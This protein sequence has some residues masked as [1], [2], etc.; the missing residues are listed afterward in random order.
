MS[1][2]C[3]LPK[4]LLLRSAKRLRQKDL[5]V[6]KENAKLIVYYYMLAKFFFFL[7]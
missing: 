3:S 2:S 6:M 4:E 5:C 1:K 7:F